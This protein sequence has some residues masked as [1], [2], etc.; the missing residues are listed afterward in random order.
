VFLLFFRP[1]ETQLNS[2]LFN[3]MLLNF[4]ST[5][6]IHMTCLQLDKLVIDTYIYQLLQFTGYT[7]FFRKFTQYSVFSFA[8]LGFSCIT[9]ITLLIR[10][11]RR[12]K[13]SE[14]E[15]SMNGKKKGKKSKD[16]DED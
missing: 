7:T 14:L 6:I 9:L 12:L 10:G 2:F 1:N 5:A 13:Y 16:E 8:L 11:G 3:A 4:F 15:K